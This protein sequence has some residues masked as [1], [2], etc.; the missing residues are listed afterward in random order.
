MIQKEPLLE[1][2]YKNRIAEFQRVMSTR[3]FRERHFH[4]WSQEIMSGKNF[5]CENC[6]R[7]RDEGEHTLE[8]LK[9]W[10]GE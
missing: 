1:Q 10:G 3:V 4:P 7:T 6:G 2:E 9:S 5:L 8:C